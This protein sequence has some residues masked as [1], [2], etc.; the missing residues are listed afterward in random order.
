[1]YVTIAVGTRWP[2]TLG[3]PSQ[4]VSIL[5]EKFVPVVVYVTSLVTMTLLSWLV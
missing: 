3:Y 2:L 1:M 4:R 5:A